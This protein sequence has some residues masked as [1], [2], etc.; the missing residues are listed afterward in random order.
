MFGRMA[1]GKIERAAGDETILN[2]NTNNPLMQQ[3]RDV[4]RNETFRL[5]L[6]AIY[7]NA[8]MFAHHYVSPENAEI[9]F[10]T[11]NA[12]ISEMISS[13]RTLEEAQA[14]VAHMEIE[15]NALKGFVA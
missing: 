7:N 2:L 13:S 1:K 5:A 9:I 14:N 11:N 10:T 12:A 3:L 4:N 6:T 15:L 8:M